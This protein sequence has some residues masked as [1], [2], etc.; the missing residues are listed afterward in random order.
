LHDGPLIEEW[1]FEH[2]PDSYAGLYMEGAP[3]NQFRVGFTHHQGARISSIKALPG[4]VAPGR[5]HRF[6]YVPRY[7]MEELI[8]LEQM[9][10]DDLLLGNA[11]PGAAISVGVIV[12]RNIVM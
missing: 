1:A 10:V 3:S 12:Q 8:S 6:R 9:A 11:H 7:S 2:Y 4:L 5:V